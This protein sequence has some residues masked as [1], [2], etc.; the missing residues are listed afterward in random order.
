MTI[1]EA[2]RQSGNPEKSVKTHPWIGGV[3]PV[4]GDM[5]PVSPAAG[6][7]FQTEGVTPVSFL[8]FCWK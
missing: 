7:P 1:V 5:P 8:N 3:D 2:L 4:S 6:R